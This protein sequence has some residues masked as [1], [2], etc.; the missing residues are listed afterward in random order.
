[1]NCEQNRVRYLQ[2]KARGPGRC[3]RRMS[4]IEC[5]RLASPVGRRRQPPP[6]GV[7]GALGTLQRCLE[8]R[9][10]RVVWTT[11][12]P[13]LTA[14]CPWTTPNISVSPHPSTLAWPWRFEQGQGATAGFSCGKPGHVAKDCWRVRQAT[15]PNQQSTGAGTGQ[16]GRY[17]SSATTSTSTAKTSTL[18]SSA[19]QEDKI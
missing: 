13:Q 15:E 3:Q 16:Q 7:S 2:K 6:C 10:E 1:M 14:C 5:A 8:N 4:R 18:L 17:S 11:P 12:K 19:H 9:A